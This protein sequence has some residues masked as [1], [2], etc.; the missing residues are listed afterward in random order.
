MAT[1]ISITD[2][3]DSMLLETAYLSFLSAKLTASDIEMADLAEKKG[4]FN[5]TLKN[6]AHSV[7][8][9]YLIAW[10][11]RELCKDI[12]GKN[13]VEFVESDIYYQKYK[14]YK[15][16]AADYE[17]EITREMLVGTID[18][19]RERQGPRVGTLFIGG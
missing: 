7:V 8:K 18:N 13:K 17:G 9:K 10:V 2:I 11:C 14:L 19:I 16:E 15:S 1:Y 3:T 4:A 12:I 5:V 6:P